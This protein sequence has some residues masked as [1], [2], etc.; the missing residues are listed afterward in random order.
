[1]IALFKIVRGYPAACVC[2]CPPGARDALE[3]YRKSGRSLLSFCC[4]PPGTSSVEKAA[5]D[6]PKKTRHVS[7]RPTQQRQPAV[8]FLS[9][10]PFSLSAHSPSRLEAILPSSVANH[11]RSMSLRPAAARRVSCWPPKKSCFGAEMDGRG[12]REK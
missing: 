1:M 12:R 5:G 2:S 8:L 6:V 9:P 4:Y 3:S 7:S 11:G 10:W